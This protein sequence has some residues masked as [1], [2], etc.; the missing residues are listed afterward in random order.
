[1]TLLLADESA[2]RA[3]FSLNF[4][5]RPIVFVTNVGPVPVYFAARNF[6]HAFY[7][8]T[9]RDGV[10]DAFSPVRAERMDD[11]AAVLADPS[12]PRYIGWDKASRQHDATRCVCIASGDF[13]VVIRLRVTS[14]GGLAANFVT[15][16]VADNSIG[17]IRSAPAW[18]ETAC[19]AALQA[20]KG[21]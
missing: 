3:H 8:S 17:K 21:R 6:E 12:A 1:M 7:E 2:Y 19:L 14:S 4:C 13:V 5:S 15:C 11:I 10:K 20:R 16:Y 18:N 9:Y